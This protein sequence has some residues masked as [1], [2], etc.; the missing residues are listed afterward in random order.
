MTSEI[1]IYNR[2]RFV[3]SKK[4][5]RET[6]LESLNI[7]K[8]KR[9]VEMAVLVVGEKEIRQLNRV[10]RHKDRTTNVL[11]FP[12][13]TETELKKFKR[14]NVLSSNSGSGSRKLANPLIYRDELLNKFDFQ[15][16]NMIPLGQILINP[17]QILSE[18][19]KNQKN[20]NRELGKLLVHGLLHL[21]GHGHKTRRQEIRMLKKENELLKKLKF[22]I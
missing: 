1:L 15:T 16:K 17:R 14:L 22:R 2:T 5:I 4:L 20:F 7:L 12:Q 21:L 3:V 11:A 9:P 13:I 19:G 6:I 18:I 10:W 8:L